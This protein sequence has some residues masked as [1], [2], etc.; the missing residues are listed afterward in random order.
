MP[1]ELFQA[2]QG[3]SMSTPHVSGAAALLKALQP[4]WTPD[5]IKS[6]LMTTAKTAQ[7]FKED[8][9]TPCDPFDSGSGRIDLSKAGNP[10]LTFKASAQ[11]YLTHQ[12]ALWWVNYPSLYIPA[13]SGA[14]TVP[15]TIHSELSKP[16][17][18]R[19]A[20]VGPTDLVVTAPKFLF[21]L[22]G[23]IKK[24]NITVDASAVP[25]GAVCHAGLHLT[26]HGFQVI[27]PITIVRQ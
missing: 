23:G 21:I 17:L 10:G 1:G 12:T 13:L 5:Q 19:V 22:P 16:S 11:D 26:H 7:L 4:A 2:I 9:I 18:W 8:G 3:T 15:R 25:A 24:F 20:V 27:V 6:A 14:I